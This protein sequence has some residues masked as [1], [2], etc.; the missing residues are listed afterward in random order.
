MQLWIATR[1]V[2][3]WTKWKIIRPEMKEV[4]K[5]HIWGFWFGVRLRPSLEFFLQVKEDL[6]VLCKLRNHMIWFSFQ[7]SLWGLLN[8]GKTRSRLEAGKLRNKNIWKNIIKWFEFQNQNHEIILFCQILWPTYDR[9][10]NNYAGTKNTISTLKCQ[11]SILFTLKNL[12]FSL[13]FWGFMATHW[14]T[15]Y[16]LKY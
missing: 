6:W 13:I 1:M 8:T 9:K 2:I 5:V 12:C 3:K 14:T 7:K 4:S 10:G 15:Y 11:I 16:G